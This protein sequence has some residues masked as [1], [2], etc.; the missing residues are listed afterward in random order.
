MRA[1]PRGVVL[2]TPEQ[3]EQMRAAGALVARVLERL[4][5][6]VAPGVTTGELDELAE[7]CIRE[8]GAVPSFLGYHGFPATICASVGAEVVHG[9]PSPRRVLQEGELLSLDCGAVVD[10]WHG[11]AA[12][13]VPVGRCSPDLLDLVEVTRQAMEAGVAAARPGGRLSDIG[14][15]VEAVVRPRGYGL[16]ADYTGHGIGRALHEP[17]DVPNLAP[18][19]PGRGLRLVPGLVIAVEPMVVLGDPAVTELDD[20]WTVVT[21]DGRQAAHFEHTVAVTESGPVVLTAPEA[22]RPGS[23]AP[24]ARPA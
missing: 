6:A 13:T 5:A 19:G 23:A 12:V 2:K 3:V 16:V 17:P 15:A 4:R 9:I 10:G 24:A 22:D 18:R 8:A 7:S 20:G 1:R 14:A 11:D 21:D